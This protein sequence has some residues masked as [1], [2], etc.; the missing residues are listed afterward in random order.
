MNKG[1]QA[2][3]FFTNSLHQSGQ[4]LFKA[5]VMPNA[6]CRDLAC[7]V[8][9]AK[10]WGNGAFPVIAGGLGAGRVERAYR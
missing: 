5:E 6:E 2:L 1:N 9:W 3:F 7:R 10:R 8:E 4:F